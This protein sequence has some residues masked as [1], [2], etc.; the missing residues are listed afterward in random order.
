MNTLRRGSKFLIHLILPS[1]YHRSGIH[2][3]E[4]QVDSL[5]EFLFAVHPDLSEHA[6]GHL[7]EH[8]LHQIEP[9]AVLGNEDE[10]KALR[11]TR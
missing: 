6:A 1:E 5:D 10:L 7:A 3:L 4:V 11:P 9:R 2:F 8:I